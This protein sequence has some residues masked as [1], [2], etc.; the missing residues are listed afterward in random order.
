MKKKH[1]NKLFTT[2]DKASAIV[3]LKKKHGCKLFTTLD[4]ATAIVRSTPINVQKKILK[5]QFS[6]QQFAFQDVY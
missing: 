1:G 6:N 2:L 4:K 3:L 5:I